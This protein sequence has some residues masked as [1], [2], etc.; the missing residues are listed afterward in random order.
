MKIIFK[1]SIILVTILL[2]NNGLAAENIIGTWQGK[3]VNPPETELTIQFIISQAPDGSYAVILDSPDQGAIKDIKANSVVVYDSG[4]LKMDVADLNAAYEGVVKDGKIEGK[5][6]QG[7]TSMPLSLALDVK[8]VLAQED[9]EKLLGL[10]NG[11]FEYPGGS[12]TAV[13]RFEMTEDGKFVG[14]ADYPDLGNSTPVS[15]VMIENGSVIIKVAKWEAEYKGK[16]TGDEI[17]GELKQRGPARPLTL[18]KGGYYALNLS[19]EDM[20]ELMDSKDRPCALPFAFPA[21][22]NEVRVVMVGDM[23]GTRETP[24]LAAELACTLATNDTP[25]TLAIEMS[26]DEQARLDAYL[27]SDGGETARY[28]L[29]ESP[30]WRFRQDGLNTAATFAMIDRIRVLRQR[31]ASLAVLAIDASNS[32]LAQPL[33]TFT[34]EQEQK[35]RTMLKEW[36]M[37]EQ[38]IPQYLARLPRLIMRDRAMARH[39]CDATRADPA[40]RFVVLA[41]NAHTNKLATGGIP[42]KPPMASILMQDVKSILS[43][44]TMAMKYNFWACSANQGCGPQELPFNEKL[45][46]RGAGVHMGYDSTFNQDGSYDGIIIFEHTT[47]APPGVSL[48]SN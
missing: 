8:P 32:D 42:G 45:A 12:L 13:Y 11:K 48:S 36:G 40:R 21:A 18:K 47:P 22:I 27:A 3:L 25:V 44:N 29:I 10:W 23:H 28:A 34:T 7:R 9:K 15:D 4:K 35:L 5:W 19:E 1:L 38:Q 43:L 14:F 20:K 41:G 26:H 17:V 30:F 46:N 33:P 6:M 24:R 31:G 16:M 37:Q 2:F 39:M